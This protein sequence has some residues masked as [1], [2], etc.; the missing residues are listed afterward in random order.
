MKLSS[1]VKE[2][3]ETLKVDASVEE[4]LTLNDEE[5]VSTETE[6][7]NGLNMDVDDETASEIKTLTAMGNPAKTP[8][9]KNSKENNTDEET[10]AEL[11]A[12]KSLAGI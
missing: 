12:L 5:K 6:N 9:E 7:N 11:D 3:N 8:I 4:E 2:K 10:Q 1:M